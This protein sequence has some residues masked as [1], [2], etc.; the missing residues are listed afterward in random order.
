LIKRNPGL[1]PPI[2]PSDALVREIQEVLDLIKPILVDEADPAYNGYGGAATEA[3]LH[4][5]G[6]RDSGLRVM[7][8]GWGEGGHWWLEGP[9]GVIDLTL[10][11][12]DRRYLTEHPRASYPYEKGTGAMFQDGYERP[13]ERAAAIIELVKSRR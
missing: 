9:E 1:R 3:Y 2:A 4:L 11:P 13:S 10:G 6:G 8:H 12:A 7:R 5:A